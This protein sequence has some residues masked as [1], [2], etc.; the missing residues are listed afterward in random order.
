MSNTKAINN[1]TNT[2]ALYKLQDNAT[3]FV[4]NAFPLRR[5]VKSNLDRK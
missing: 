2:N 5:F 1:S 3:T 4:S